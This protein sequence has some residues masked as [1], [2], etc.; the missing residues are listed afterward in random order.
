MKKTLAI[1]R[2]WVLLAALLLQLA[3]FAQTKT[4]SGKVT[5][6]DGE[7]LQGVSVS[8][9]GGQSVQTGPD[10]S[11]TLQA[12]PGARIQFSSVGFALQSV[13]LANESSLNIL[14]TREER[15]MDEVVVVGYGTQSRRSVTTSIAK[16]DKEVLASAPRG[17]IGGALQGSVPG[18]QVV[19]GTGQPGAAPQILLRGGASIN[20]P[21]APLVVVDGVIRSFN[22]IPSEDIA[23]IELL[24]DAASTAIYGARANNGVILITTKQGR[25]GKAE[26]SY[27][28]V[29]GYNQRRDIYNYFDAKDF[30]YY[31]RLGNFNS[32]RTL[33]QVN[34][35]RGYGIPASRAD[36]ASF[37]IR[38]F[39]GTNAHLL[40]MGW[41]TVG[42]PYGGTIIFKDHGGEVEDLVFR[43][44]YTQDHYVNVTGGND[45]GKYFASF[46]YYSEDGIIV[47]SKYKRYSGNINGSYKVR[48]N[49]EVST[50]VNMSTASNYGTIGGEINTL[51]RSMAIWPTFNPWLDSAKT[52]PNPG[53]GSADGNPLYWLSRL[54]RK[55]EVNRIT[56]NAAVKWD[57]LPGLYV[58]ATGNAYLFEQ[59]DQSFQKATQNYTNI[60]TTPQSYASTSR[61]SYAL[62]QRSFQQQYNAVINYTKTFADRHTVGA[63]LGAEYFGT[64]A[65][66]MQVLGTNAPTDDIPTVNAST[67][68]VAGNN[69][70]NESE[71][72]ILSSFGRL[73]YDYDN[74]FLLTGVFRRDGVS[75]L[76]S[77]NRWGFFPGMSA[78][79]NLHNE[80]FYQNLGLDK[81]ISTFKPRVSYGENGNVA[82]LGRYEV[83][84]GY[85]GQG[86]YNGAA[87]FLNTSMINS[88]LRW[89][90]SKTVDVGLDLAFLRNKITVIFDYYNRKTSD[91]LTNLSLPSYT[92]FGSFRTNLGTFQNKGIEVSVNAA[93]LNQP[94]GFSLN[95]G[96]NASFVKNKILELPFNGNDAN[97]QGGLQVY[98]PRQGRVVW[99]GGLQEG[100]S[101]GDIYAFQQVSI[102]ANQ[103]EIVKEAN[104]RRDLIAQ[105]GG[106]GVNYGSG[107][108]APGDVN[109][110]DVDRND[111]IDSRDQVYM[112]NIYPKWTGGFSANL[113]YKG[114]SLY[115][116]F[117]FATGHTI[118][119]DLVARTLGNYQGTFN[120]FDLQKEAWSPTNTR[121]DVPKVYYADQVAA[122]L[123]KKNYTRSNNANGVLNSNNSRFYEKGD[124]LALRELTLSYE[125][126]R[127]V[128]AKTGVLSQSR[129][130]VSANNLFY[131]TKF[132]GPS[133]EPPVSGGVTTG[134]YAG[135]YPTPKTYVLGVQ[136]S[137]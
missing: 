34:S 3:T 83:Q 70:T 46:D 92:G 55:N 121:T 8:V 16:L 117:E 49:V 68:F 66:D 114:L 57:I 21:G 29:G 113:G 103:E 6:P 116:R 129:V 112:G 91:L 98:D 95:L 28:F 75:S 11:F 122:P 69:Y 85:G 94:N 88:N 1:Q 56:A 51:Y 84:G 135:T 44:T 74:R 52:Q 58:R 87:T 120:Y 106:P 102:F 132:S 81:Y 107:K 111:T 12:A 125:F 31:N 136:V 45:K 63:M 13:T 17:N 72:R 9:Q 126:P 78:G 18:L 100:R 86:L 115:T 20:N 76:A 124:Y 26:I 64:K 33:S 60:F 5:G 80:A 2:F 79:W 39:D 73:T 82:G 59:L 105:I 65:F 67:T 23:S 128:L 36:S 90:N 53:N 62:W 71:Y 22:D 43:N 119:N 54:Q 109:W 30:I 123:G 110:L 99:V 25:S 4:I 24:K 42:D 41:D 96:G 93:V 89:E 38:K 127:S 37:D 101:M 47:G 104:T 131:L 32:G 7:A 19:N 118:Y 14:L 77:G 48:P 27:K 134:V 40:N 137:F 15:K 97:R 50:G 130:Y 35:S 10:G 61:Q 108:I 133:P